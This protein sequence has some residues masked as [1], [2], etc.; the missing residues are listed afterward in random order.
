MISIITDRILYLCDSIPSRL[1]QIPKEKI[2]AK[3]SEDK[4]SK[5][6][7]LG[8]LIDSAVNNHQR[9]VRV[10]FEESPLIFYDQDRWVKLQDYQNGD[11]EG[12]I[13]FWEIYNRH[14]AFIIN[15]I[16]DCNL[17]RKCIGKEGKKSDLEFLIKDYLNHMEYHLLQILDDH[18]L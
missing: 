2:V 10:Q 9:F 14:L 6:E 7:I 1:R 5:K 17:L 8:H 16:P 18:P 3:I 15:K 12:L 11:I 13:N 4:W